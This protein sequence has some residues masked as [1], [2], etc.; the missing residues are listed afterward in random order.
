MVALIEEWR[1]LFTCKVHLYVC[2]VGNLEKIGT[3]DKKG[4]WVAYLIYF[5]QWN[6][7]LQ[8]TCPIEEI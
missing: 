5:L 3:T 6:I 8:N 7:N 2:Q 1:F 4:F